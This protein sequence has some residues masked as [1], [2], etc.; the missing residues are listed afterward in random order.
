MGR[1]GRVLCLAT[2]AAL[3]ASSVGVTSAASAID[4]YPSWA[5]VEAAR[6][7]ETATAAEVV[8]IESALDGLQARAAELGDVA[9]TQTSLS[10]EAQTRFG[11]A[12][13]WHTVLTARAEEASARS[14]ASSTRLGAL[15]AQLY[16]SGGGSLSVSAL[17][18]GAH[19][20]DLLFRLG[21]MSRLT[22]QAGRL[23]EQADA[24]RNAA[25]ALT[26]QAE[27]MTRERDRL[28]NKARAALAA[29]QTAQRAAD[30]EVAV[31]QATGETLYAQLASLKNSS[32]EVERQYRTGVAEHQAFVEQ[33][34]QAAA[35]AAAAASAAAAS[36]SAPGTPGTAGPPPTGG[37]VD[38]GAAQKIAA[39]QVA[40]RGWSS[41]ELGCLVSLWQRES[42]WR[43]N[44][45][46]AS[47]GAYGIPQSLPG[48]K[49]QSAGDDW[50]TNPATQISWGLGYIASRYTTPCGAWAHSESNNWY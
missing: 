47:S 32:T 28:Q 45:Y 3:V 12:N 8:R 9:V 19:A 6:S 18:D 42:G 26:A 22:E 43:V 29:T 14:V 24:E 36:P 13:A 2:A 50:Q 35:N 38:R 10:A 34:R 31:K 46:N 33:Q 41:A 20:D 11:T 21:T 30:A 4:E 40:A 16:R 39:V 37:V 23:T 44:A 48:S 7:S 5:D 1:W 27:V 15:G 17:F 49:M 25:E